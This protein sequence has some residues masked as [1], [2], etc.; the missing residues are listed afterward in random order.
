[1]QGKGGCG[2]DVV[3]NT[4]GEVFLLAYLVLNLIRGCFPLPNTSPSHPLTPLQPINQSMDAFPFPLLAPTCLFLKMTRIY[5]Y[6]DIYI[7]TYSRTLNLTDQS[8][9]QKKAG[10]MGGGGRS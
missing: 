7:Y 2:G 3:E 9:G 1:M 6:I 10:E 8:W 5:K 4:T